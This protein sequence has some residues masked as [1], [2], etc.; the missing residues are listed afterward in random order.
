MPPLRAT[1][2]CQA[3]A[4]A[5]GGASGAAS[6][7]PSLTLN[8]GSGRAASVRSVIAAVERITDRKVLAA[9]RPGDPPVLVAD[10]SAARSAIGFEPQLSD[11]PVIIETAWRARCRMSQ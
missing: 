7:R 9:R 8:L 4:G 2:T 10:I 11:L 5:C 6:R 1:R 3:C